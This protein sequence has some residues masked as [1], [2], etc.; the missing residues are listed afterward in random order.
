MTRSSSRPLVSSKTL[1]AATVGAGALAGVD[2][3]FGNQFA[4]VFKEV[5]AVGLLI[6]VVILAGRWFML[7]LDAED[8]RRAEEWRHLVNTH[9]DELNRRDQ[10]LAELSASLRLLNE[11]AADRDRELS[12]AMKSL[13]DTLHLI[14]IHLVQRPCQLGAHTPTTNV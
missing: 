7:R 10:A 11:Q 12:A 14:H 1:V 9:A 3:A 4:T 6:L 13:S 8:A 5:G 2:I